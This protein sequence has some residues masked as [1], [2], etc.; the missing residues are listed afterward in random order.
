MTSVFGNTGFEHSA[1]ILLHRVLLASYG[2][3]TAS[4]CADIRDNETHVEHK[5]K[6]M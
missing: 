1:L 6:N 2:E 3:M 4:A 5:V